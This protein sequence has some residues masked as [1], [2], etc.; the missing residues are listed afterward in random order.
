MRTLILLPLALF[1][2]FVVA[3]SAGADTKTVQITKNGFTPATTTVNVGDTV[4]CHNAD[5]GQ[6][7]GVAN[8]SSFPSPP[9]NT[10][11]TYPH[12]HPNPRSFP[13]PHSPATAHTP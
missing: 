3:A 7:H 10:D 13:S 8:D 12:P 2:A 4:T 6:H 9:T 5:T 11:H 1:A